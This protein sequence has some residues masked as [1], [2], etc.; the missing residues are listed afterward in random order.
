[1]RLYIVVHAEMTDDLQRSVRLTQGRAESVVN[2]LV[3]KYGIPRE[4]LE[5]H[6]VGPLVP[7]TENESEQGRAKNRRVEIVAR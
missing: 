5:P 1:L 6:G 7:V 2:A 3:E 4:R